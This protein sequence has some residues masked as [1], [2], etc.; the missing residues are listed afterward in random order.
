MWRL[1][2][3]SYHSAAMN[4]AIDEAVS[5]WV[6]S[7]SS[8][9]TIRFYGWRPSAVSIGCFQSLAD[10]VDT[11]ACKRLGVDYVRRWTGGGAVYHDQWGEVTYSVIA[12]ENLVSKEINEEYRRICGMIVEGL[13][14]L[15]VEAE[16]HSI[17]DVL[18]EGKKISGSA[19][20]R[21]KGVFLQ[22]GTVL[23]DLEV[24]KMFSLLKV[25]HAKL[26][27]KLISEAKE[28]V[29]CL[30]DHSSASMADLISS[31]RAAFTRGI[32]F[33]QS[34]LTQKEMEEARTL[35]REKYANDEWNL[36]R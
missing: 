20:T 13:A 33:S 18:V 3:F 8:N 2:P 27:D 4:M 34:D 16:F 23:F 36:S 14:S 19:Q 26:S 1:I 5:D 32:N 30:R 24:E 12:P 11:D 6:R 25:P 35:A 15:G 28:R 29:T 10:E 21:R 17:N 31:L 9:P 7:G 22:H